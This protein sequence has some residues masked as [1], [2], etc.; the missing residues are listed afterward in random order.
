[1]GSRAGRWASASVASTA[2]ALALVVLGATA[3]ACANLA[4]LSFSVGA[5]RPGATVLV[6]G[7]SFAVPRSPDVAPTP[8][9]IRWQSRTGDVLA[10]AV[11]DRR[12]TV[13]A[14]FTVP[15]VSPGL[16][17]VVATQRTPRPAPGA[18]PDQPPVLYD[19]T[20]TPALASFQ[21][22]GAGQIL[23]SPAAPQIEPVTSSSDLDASTWIVLMVTF[24]AVAVSLFAGGLIAFI[25]QSRRPKP[26]ARE[27][28]VPEG[29]W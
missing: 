10:E 27:A 12:G 14:S 19:E 4:T 28:W 7:T 21:V 9:V 24:G 23:T 13:T 1:M 20:G 25:Y 11:P 26:T 2:A 15:Q 17:V 22:V 3:G 5:A 8:V 16:Y 18:L 29:W 6:T